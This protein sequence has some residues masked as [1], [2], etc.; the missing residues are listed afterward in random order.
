MEDIVQLLTALVHV[1]SAHF[2]VANSYMATINC[3]GGWKI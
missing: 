2:S 1:I 3:K